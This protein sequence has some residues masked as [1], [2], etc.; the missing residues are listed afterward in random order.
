MIA[1]TLDDIRTKRTTNLFPELWAVA[2][3]DPQVNALVQ[4]FYARAQRG[5]A[6]AIA[7]INPALSEE[8]CRTVAL[9]IS[10]SI[11]GT[12]IFAGHG[13]PWEARMPKIKALALTSLLQLVKTLRPAELKTSRARR[14][15]VAA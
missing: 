5:F 6:D 2:N 3:H 7:A 14:I 1:F 9:F 13:K 15:K 4:D 12:T 10:A 8:D 11:E